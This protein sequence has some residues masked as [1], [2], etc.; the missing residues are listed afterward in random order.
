[1]YQGIKILFAQ[2]MEQQNYFH[3]TLV[4]VRGETCLLSSFHYI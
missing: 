4:A 3:V 1:M 2:K